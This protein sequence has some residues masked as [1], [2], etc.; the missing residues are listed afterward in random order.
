VPWLRDTG[1][2]AYRAFLNTRDR[3]FKQ[4]A[5]VDRAL[6][7]VIHSLNARGEFGRATIVVTSDHGSRNG[8]AGADDRHVPLVVYSPGGTRQ[9]IYEPVQVSDIL[10]SVVARACGATE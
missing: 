8:H 6:G 2:F 9:D 10:K 7:T 1:P 5:E 3:Y 4:L